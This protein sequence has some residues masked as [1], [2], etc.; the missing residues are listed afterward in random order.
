MPKK[1]RIKVRSQKVTKH[2]NQRN[3]MHRMLF[4]AILYLTSTSTLTSTAK[5][6]CLYDIIQLY[7]SWR[8]SRGLV[9]YCQILI[10]VFCIK[11]HISVTEFPKDPKCVISFYLRRHLSKIFSRKMTSYLSHCGVQ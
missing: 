6:I 4:W 5:V 8:S 10:S 1:V 2:K 3:V 7:Y 9:K 11:A